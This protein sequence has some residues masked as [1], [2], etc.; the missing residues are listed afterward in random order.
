MLF[1]RGLLL[2]LTIAFAGHAAPPAPT[3]TALAPR[4]LITKEIGVD[5][6]ATISLVKELVKKMKE[7]PTN[8]SWD[9]MISDTVMKQHTLTLH[10]P[11]N[12]YFYSDDKYVITDIIDLVLDD[13]DGVYDETKTSGTLKIYRECNYPVEI[14]MLYDREKR[15][16]KKFQNPKLNFQKGYL[17]QVVYGPTNRVMVVLNIKGDEQLAN[18]LE[19]RLAY[20]RN[21]IRFVD[22]YPVKDDPLKPDPADAKKAKAGVGL[23]NIHCECPS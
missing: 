7:D 20:F 8:G 19:E 5:D 17:G 10:K 16:E 6:E 22:A 11:N 18:T 1:I 13:P 9:D 21:N 12:P 4:P 3:K 15:A 23:T 2:V 14:E